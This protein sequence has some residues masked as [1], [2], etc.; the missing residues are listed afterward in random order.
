MNT[1]QR[2]HHGAKE[3]G[4]TLSLLIWVIILILLVGSALSLIGIRIF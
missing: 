3:P 4:S 1:E 2:P